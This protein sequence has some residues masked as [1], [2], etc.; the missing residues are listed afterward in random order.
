VMTADTRPAES[1]LLAPMKAPVEAMTDCVMDGQT[2]TVTT[3]DKLSYR[4][5]LVLEW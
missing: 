1:T 4:S 2:I 5:F 3:R